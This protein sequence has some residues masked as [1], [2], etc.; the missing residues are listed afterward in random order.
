MT[1]E[2]KFLSFTS[3]EFQVQDGLPSMATEFRDLP[4]WSSLNALIFISAINDAFGVLISSTD[5]SKSKTLGDLFT[6]I[7]SSK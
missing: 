1:S 4:N 2:L 5:L 6:I 7:Q 3:K